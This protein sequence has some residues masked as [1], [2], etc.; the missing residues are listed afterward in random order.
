MRAKRYTGFAA[1]DLNSMIRIDS[2]EQIPALEA[3]FYDLSAI[4]QRR[5][6]MSGY[7]KAAKPLIN[8]AKTLVPKGRTKNLY[9]SIGFKTLP[10]D[11]AV[12]VGTRQSGGFKGWHGHLVE[13]GTKQRQYL[14]ST[15]KVHKTG[16]ARGT[17]FFQIA[18]QQTYEQ[19]N[20]AI[21][22]EWLHAIDRKVMS[23]N[24]RL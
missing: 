6:F 2:T 11:I 23:I 3:F 1:K 21:A 20:D 7:K 13:R 17:R 5:I 8:A 4:D 22:A 15:G 16:A 12:I 14:T 18:Y 24:K 10:Y 9:N 19:I